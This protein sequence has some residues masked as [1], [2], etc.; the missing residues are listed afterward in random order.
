MRSW[1]RRH[2]RRNKFGRN[3]QE[4]TTKWADSEAAVA[5]NVL[6]SAAPLTLSEITL[7]PEREPS[8]ST[9]L[10]VLSRIQ[11]EPT[12]DDEPRKSFWRNA[13]QMLQDDENNRKLLE[14]YQKV[15]REESGM[16]PPQHGE[17]A[18]VH[19]SKIINNNLKLINE[20]HWTIRVGN[21]TVELKTV[22]NNVAKAVQYA[23]SFIGT[24]VSG[25]PH[26]AMA[27]AGVSLFLPVGLFVFPNNSGSQSI[28]DY[29]F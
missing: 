16:T 4:N 18:P 10:P 14:L 3:D 29:S 23:Q 17:E 25:E 7:K 2:V 15:L 8:A 6:S 20:Q 22:L 21:I 12:R 13:C 5:E 1:F 27:W 9:K 19:L 28:M 26:T 24:I 11:S